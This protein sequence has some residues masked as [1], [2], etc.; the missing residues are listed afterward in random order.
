M[1][2]R[3]YLITGRV[4]GV[5]FRHA[6]AVEARHLGLT[7]WVRNRGY[8]SVEAVASGETAALDALDRWAHRGPAAARVVAVDV[9]PATAAE[10]ADVDPGF[11]QRPSA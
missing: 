5:G 6:M 3:H 9:R 8:D 4:Q 2:A 10:A 11:S 1:P 7:G